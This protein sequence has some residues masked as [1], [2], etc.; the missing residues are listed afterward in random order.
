MDVTFNPTDVGYG[1]GCGPNS[2]VSHM[3]LRPDGK[4]LIAGWFNSYEASGWLYYIALLDANGSL[5]ATF[6]GATTNSTIDKI[7][8]RPDNKVVV[9]GAFTT[10]GGQ[11]RSRLAQ[12]M[13]DGSLDPSFSIGTGFNGQVNEVL[14]L[15]DGKMIAVGAFTSFNGNTVG[16]IVRLNA[17]GSYDPTFNAG[18]GFSTTIADVERD[19]AG[20]LLVIS[21]TNVTQYNGVPLPTVGL[22]RLS[23]DGLLDASYQPAMSTAPYRLKVLP[24]GSAYTI[25]PGTNTIHRFFESGATDTGFSSLPI[26]GFVNDIVLDVYNRPVIHGGVSQVGAEP[27]GRIA[28]WTTWGT[29]DDSFNS[30]GKFDEGPWQ[31]TSLIALPSGQMICSGEFTRYGDK[32][33]IRLVRVNSGGVFDPTFNPATGITGNGTMQ[34]WNVYDMARQ[35]DGKLIVC[36]KFRGYNSDRL[37]GFVRINVNGSRDAAFPAGNG[38]DEEGVRAVA[39]QPDGKILIGGS[40]VQ[41]NGAVVNRIA[42]LMPD[43]QLDTGFNPGGTGLSGGVNKIKIKILPDGKILLGGSFTSYNGVAVSGVIRLNA[44]GSL[45]NSFSVNVTN[46]NDIEPRSDGSVWIGGQFSTVNGQTRNR[47][48]LLTAGGSLD[49][50]FDPGNGPSGFGGIVMDLVQRPDGRLIVGGVFSSFNGVTARGVIQLL[51]NGAI[52]P[53]FAPPVT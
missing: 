22:A 30:V 24:D 34:N 41:Y 52:D 6:T 53:A 48:A 11:P 21:G 46:I 18:T 2:L 16:R 15:P 25:D 20:R 1:R 4:I 19:S 47:V 17:N 35:A 51:D 14:F 43:G 8:V 36:G 12:L 7:Y 28:R 50:S 10:Y 38:P 9:T 29:L 44:N 27:A 45:D 39:I 37:N 33:A 31:I 13:A 40:F 26:T 32:V 23:A 42:R 3:A 5:D 49:T